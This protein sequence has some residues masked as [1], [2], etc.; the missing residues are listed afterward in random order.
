[1]VTPE[2]PW[3]LLLMVCLVGG[4]FIVYL[5]ARLLALRNQRLALFTALV[6]A[7]ALG[8]LLTLAAPARNGGPIPIWEAFQPGGAAMRLDTGALF[9][10]AMTLGL[11]LCVALYSACYLS[12]DLRYKMYYPLLLLLSVGVLG[13]VM[14]TD[15]FSLYMFCELMSVTAYVLVA[16]RRHLDTAVEAGFKYLIMGSVG[17][18]TLL[19]GIAFVYRETGV[20]ALPQEMA[21]PGVWGR[22]GLACILTGLSV[23]C[24]LV[25]AHTWLPDTYGR[26][27][28]SISAM[29]SGIVAAAVFYVLLKTTLGLGFPARD[30]GGLLMLLAF[31]NMT[32]GNFMALVQT[33]T[34]RLLAYSSVAQLGY[35]MFGV[36]VGLRYDLPSAVQSGFF[37][38]LTQAVMK[39]LAF[40]SKG[41]CH[42]YCHTSLV[43]E[44]RGTFQRMPL[45][46]ITFSIALLG[47]IGLPPLAGF[48]G[49][50]FVLA[51]MLRTGDGVVFAGV[52][53]FLLNTLISLGYYLPLIAVLFAPLPE[54]APAG[55]ISLSAWMVAPLLILAALVVLMGI[56][57]DPWLRWS[58]DVLA[59]WSG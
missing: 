17:T 50:W 45:A 21:S 20:L 39:A 38:L 41:V 24:A 54:G 43:S 31:L 34:K 55:T 23:K 1:M 15:L 48:A 18:L 10:G 28:S 35:V 4:A 5:L 46:A 49:K 11:G 7:L 32:V 6:F 3:V 30:L 9:I 33:N 29:L 12:L 52:V 2:N 25:P 47:M 57:P 37:L 27:P 22:V 13:M 44:L 16:F 26:A 40:L 53:L 42:F 19:L 8:I 56:A 14:S 58:A 51:E 36:G 59:V